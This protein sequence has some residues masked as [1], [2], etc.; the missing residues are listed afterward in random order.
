[1]IA[2][3][4]ENLQMM[5]IENVDFKKTS[6]VNLPFD[7]HTFD[8]VISNGVINLIPDKETAMSEIYRVLKPTGR[9]MAADQI[10]CGSVQKDIKSRLGNWF[11]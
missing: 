11:Q 5:N 4:V 2:R 8:V 1:M 10:A 7:D 6:G 9:L 3:A